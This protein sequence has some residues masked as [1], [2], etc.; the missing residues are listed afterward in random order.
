MSS[1][2]PLVSG[3]P[4]VVYYVRY[5]ITPS[6]L[7]TKIPVSEVSTLLFPAVK[8]IVDVRSWGC[9]GSQQ[10]CL[11]LGHVWSKVKVF[12]AGTFFPKI[13]RGLLSFNKLCLIFTNWSLS[14]VGLQFQK[15]VTGVCWG[16]DALSVRV[17]IIIYMR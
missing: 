9:G 10:D 6:D 8:I 17:P 14:L 3:Q 15:R 1:P 13:S 7:N 12:L 4:C 5:G 16:Q 11:G 2:W